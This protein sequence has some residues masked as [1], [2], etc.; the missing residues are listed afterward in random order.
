[1]EKCKLCHKEK[2]L[3]ESHIIPKFVYKWMKQTGTG[4][5]RQGLNINKPIQDGIKEFLL[6]RDC[7]QK[8]SKREDWFKKNVFSRFIDKGVTTFYPSDN[9]KYFAVS[10]LWR[11]L[12]YFKDDGNNYKFKEKLDEAE[13][14][15]RKYLYENV[16]LKK[17]DSIH[18]MCNPDDIEIPN[19]P[20]NIYSYLL[21]NVDIEIA[22]SEEKCFI[23]AKFARFIFIGVIEGLENSS[24]IETDISHSINTNIQSINDS[25]VGGFIINRA[26]NSKSFED[27]SK[28]QQEKNNQYF[29]NRIDKIRGNDYWNQFLK[30]NK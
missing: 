23:Y 5:L 1:M 9:L 29:E 26:K 6:C 3:Q 19:A 24:F 18:L 2:E 28:E 14:E 20:K 16:D 25:D 30:D 7:E 11:V 4:R 22:E 8:F 10:L 17:Y 13:I 12:V 15:W 27:L 21:R